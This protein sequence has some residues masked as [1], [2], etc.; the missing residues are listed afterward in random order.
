MS[1]P[2]RPRA[3]REP[4]QV[5]LASDDSALLTRLAEESGLSKAE[6]LRRG[7]R[8]YARERDASGSPMLR[9]LDEAIEHGATAAGSPDSHGIESVAEHHDEIAFKTRWR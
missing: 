4:V 7:V 8:S 9:F 5:Y 1:K 3:V 6:I 2:T